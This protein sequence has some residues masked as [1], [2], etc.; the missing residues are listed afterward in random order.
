MQQA[1][2]YDERCEIL[3]KC[4]CFLHNSVDF[5]YDIAQVYLL[6]EIIWDSFVMNIDYLSEY[7]LQKEQFLLFYEILSPF[8]DKEG[9]SVL[10]SIFEKDQ[11]KTSLR[12]T[13]GL[14]IS[15]TEGLRTF[16][17]YLEL[18]T[19]FLNLDIIFNL[20]N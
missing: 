15:F 2:N 13:Q 14:K 5:N 11:T 10:H 17:G 20:D 12:L 16:C 1:G 6:N 3:Q 8:T 9:S 18:L 19:A 4:Y 7:K